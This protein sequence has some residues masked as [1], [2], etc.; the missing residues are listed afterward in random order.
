M[1]VLF[2]ENDENEN[3]INESLR[4]IQSGGVILY[5]SDTIWGIGCDATNEKS[6]KKVYL[7]KKRSINKQLILLVNNVEMLL[8]YVEKIDDD[9]IQKILKFKKPTTVIYPRPKNLPKIL[10]TT[11]SIAIRITKDYFCSKLISKINKTLISTSANISMEKNPNNFKSIN[12]RI[13]DMVD[14]IVNYKT[15]EELVKASKIIKINSKNE[16]E[17][18]RN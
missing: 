4:I 3:I 14:Y 10:T 16:I 9:I 8:N 6:I 15:G 17:I 2:I 11:N 18:I 1:V 7:I 5:P 13:K 12:K